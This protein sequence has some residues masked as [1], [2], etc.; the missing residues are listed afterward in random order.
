MNFPTRRSL[1]I[2][3]LRS[4]LRLHAPDE[5]VD[6]RE[7]LLNAHE[8]LLRSARHGPENVRAGIRTTFALVLHHPNTLSLFV[9]VT[10]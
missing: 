8:E 6:Y 5:S 10:L 4:K 1:K 7:V 2:R 9:T 3:I